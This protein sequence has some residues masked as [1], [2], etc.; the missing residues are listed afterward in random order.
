MF[1]AFIAD[2][3][4]LGFTAYPES[5]GHDLVLRAGPNIAVAESWQADGL[6]EGD[7]IAVEGK[8]H[9]NVAVIEQALPPWHRVYDPTAKTRSADWYAVLVPASD[10]AFRAVAAAVGVLVWTRAPD[11][12]AAHRWDVTTWQPTG[13]PAEHRVT[14]FLPL[15]LPPPV[16]MAAGLPA[17]RAVTPWKVDAVRLCL[18]GGQLRT[19]DFRGTRVRAPT[20]VQRGW[21]REVSRDGRHAVYELTDAVDRP[22]LAYPE[23]ADAL[24]A[25]SP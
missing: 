25:A 22:D 7:T 4:R 20:F 13:W 9:P 17:P 5:C 8:L 24:R 3:E 12:A 15:D 6:A 23:I 2:A 16:R 14:G 10:S 21:M 19:S 18:R 11:R 1:A